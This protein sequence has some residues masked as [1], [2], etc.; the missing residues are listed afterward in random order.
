MITETVRE[1]FLRD[2]VP[3]R[4][5]GLAANLARMKSFSAL[6]Q[7]R[8]AMEGL[9]EESKLFIEWA[10]P[11]AELETQA[12]LVEL[13]LQLA[14]WH[15]NWDELWSDPAGRQAVSAAAEQWSQRGLDFSGLLN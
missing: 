9:I 12:E 14:M 8:D 2:P 5:G 3:V 7:A 1:R 4:L 13:Q 11:E 6:P 10:A 15:A